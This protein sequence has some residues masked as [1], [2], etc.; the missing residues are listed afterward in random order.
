M[1]SLTVTNLF[2]PVHTCPLR[3]YSNR[4]DSAHLCWN[5]WA[6]IELWQAISSTTLLRN[7]ILYLLIEFLN[8]NFRLTGCQWHRTANSLYSPPACP[9][10]STAEKMSYWTANKMNHNLMLHLFSPGSRSIQEEGAEVMVRKLKFIISLPGIFSRGT[11]FHKSAMTP[12]SLLT[13]CSTILKQR[14]AI[15]QVEELRWDEPCQG[16]PQH[17]HCL[18]RLPSPSGSSGKESHHQPKC[19]RLFWASLLHT[20]CLRQSGRVTPAP[21]PIWY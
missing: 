21:Q 13:K 5:L 15:C 6:K 16:D 1:I 2:D 11:N 19:I 8:G 3:T 12:N 18:C 7:V 10:M 17:C 4:R 20:W 14:A 9:T